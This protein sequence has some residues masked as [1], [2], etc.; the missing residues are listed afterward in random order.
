MGVSFLS[1]I[2]LKLTTFV[3]SFHINLKKSLDKLHEFWYN[4]CIFGSIQLNR[5]N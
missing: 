1:Q 4:S 3:K 5:A 2:L